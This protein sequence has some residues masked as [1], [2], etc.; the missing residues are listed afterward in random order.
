MGIALNQETAFGLFTAK[1]KIFRS[2]SNFGSGVRRMSENA[3][4]Q[5]MMRM[6]N[7]HYEKIVIKSIMYE[8]LALL[9]FYQGT[10]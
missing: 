9:L 3:K 10:Y 2:E 8:D 4:K 7:G 1:P 6:F 5:K